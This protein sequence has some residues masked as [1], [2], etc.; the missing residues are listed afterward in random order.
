MVSANANPSFAIAHGILMSLAVLIWFPLGVFLL[1][2]L[3]IKHTVRWHAM[4][5]SIGLAILLSGTGFGGLLSQKSNSS[6]SHVLLG[7]VIVVLFLLMP[8][9]GWFHHKHFAAT[10]TKDFKSPLH[11]WGGRILLLLALANGIT[12]LQLSK[13]KK[14]VYV[15]YGVIAA[16]CVVV[17]AGMLWLKKRALA[18]DIAERETEM[19]ECVQRA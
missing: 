6:E 11:V 3:K 4:W 13:E 14:L 12:G 7:A 2:L 16:V 9:I 17:Y 1:R 5:Q 18:T 8:V 19:H 15:V 10:G